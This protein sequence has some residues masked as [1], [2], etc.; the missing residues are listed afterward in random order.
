MDG[1]QVNEILLK[2]SDSQAAQNTPNQDAREKRKIL[3]PE[4]FNQM[5]MKRQQNETDKSKYG[6]HGFL[7]LVIIPIR[8]I[9]TGEKIRISYLFCWPISPLIHMYYF[10]S[11]QSSTSVIGVP[12]ISQ[13]KPPFSS[14]QLRQCSQRIRH[15]VSVG[16]VFPLGLR[17]SGG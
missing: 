2:E 13:V 10:P 8:S 14:I 1:L 12:V 5:K 16:M 11:G 15:S 4:T 7:L 17:V 6:V 9:F 3:L